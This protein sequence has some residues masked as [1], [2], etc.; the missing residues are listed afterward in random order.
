[1]SIVTEA[2]R[3]WR[4]LI[5]DELW[6]RGE[7]AKHINS[8]LLPKLFRH[9]PKSVEQ[10]PTEILRKEQLLHDE[11]AR[12]GAQL[13]DHEMV[14]EWDWYFLMQ[15]HGAPTRLLD[16]S[17]GYLMAV[18]FA[19]SGDFSKSEGAFVYVIDPFRLVDTIDDLE[20]MKEIK[21]AW[22]SYRSARLKK[23]R[24][25]PRSWTNVYIPGGHSLSDHPGKSKSAAPRRPDLPDSPLVID[26]AHI[27][28]RVAAQRSRF[29]AYGRNKRWLTDWAKADDSRIWRIFIHKRHFPAIKVQLRDAGMTESVIFPDLD[30]LGRELDQLWNNLKTRKS[31]SK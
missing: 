22:K 24:S 18:H 17:D 7:D 13:H 25:W 31:L 6:F 12:C 11:F 10:A 2:R 16:W 27:T 23:Q 14:D 29:M 4:L 19:V 3:E 5:E 30:G 8:T 28:R 21:K 15:H 1:M 26:Y 20:Q 9:L